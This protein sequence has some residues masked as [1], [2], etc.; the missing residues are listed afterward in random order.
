[1]LAF[2]AEL[3]TIINNGDDLAVHTWSHPYMTT[4]SNNEVLA[5]LGWTAE[6]IHNSTGGKLPKYWR[7]PYGDSDMRTTAIAREVFG[8]TALH[9]NQK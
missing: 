3:T 9:W 1:M 5:Q 8:M 7:P 2:P 6:L 4:Q